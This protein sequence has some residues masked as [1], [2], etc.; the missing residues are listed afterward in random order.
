M[1]DCPLACRMSVAVRGRFRRDKPA[2]VKL[3]NQFGFGYTYDEDCNRKEACP[4]CREVPFCPACA[5]CSAAD[6]VHQVIQTVRTS[7]SQFGSLRTPLPWPEKECDE[8]YGIGLIENW[9]ANSSAWCL[10]LDG[11]P[12]PGQP[13]AS[14]I[15]Y[16]LLRT[17]GTTEVRNK[18]IVDITNLQVDMA[19][20]SMARGGE[21]MATIMGQNEGLESMQVADGAL[22][23]GCQPTPEMRPDSLVE[24]HSQILGSWRT[25]S[26]QS[27]SACTETVDGTSLIVTRFEFAN[28]YHVLTDLI[29]VFITM[30]VLEIDPALTTVVVF[31]GHPQTVFDEVYEK[32]VGGGLK[33]LGRLT[34]ETGRAC[35]K[36]AA[37]V[38]VGYDAPIASGWG[39]P[40]PCF[41][42]S[43]LRAFAYRVLE[44]YDVLDTPQPVRPSILF[45]FRADY[46]AHPRDQDGRRRNKISNEDELLALAR[47]ATDVNVS[48]VNL[49]RLSF[50]EQ[51][52]VIRSTNILIGMHGAGLSHA[53]F[54]P[55]EAV[56]VELFPEHV[57]KK[58]HFRNL[59]RLRGHTY[60][61]WQNQDR[62]NEIDDYTTKVDIESFREVLASAVRVA[63]NFRFSNDYFGLSK[64]RL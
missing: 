24:P 48:A 58:K 14:S 18:A 30:E 12:Q 11:A 47:A 42:S 26:A 57:K 32:L 25:A 39:K 10:P 27:S 41:D 6:E 44:I 46:V 23:G 54:L 52:R 34:G 5:E 13:A 28:W 15:Q 64:V 62:R 21:L 45:V 40:N 19:K 49:E 53:V 17:M 31:D 4:S 51:L 36:R 63:R 16:H 55:E 60:L 1:P 9:R 2:F 33:R 35:F 61:P 37:F 3:A 20:V 56:V 38:P 43:V 22:S 50:K 8:G 59:A 7:G 29:N